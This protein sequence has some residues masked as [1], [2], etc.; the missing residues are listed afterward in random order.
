MGRDS[1]SPTP[2]TSPGRRSFQGFNASSMRCGMSIVFS[3]QPKSRCL[4]G[5][6]QP[7][8]PFSFC[9][10]SYGVRVAFL[11]LLLDASRRASLK[12][13]DSR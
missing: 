10:Q 7:A 11:K 12:E 6:G 9:H 1:N 13:A 2:A 5:V 4:C 8:P 3:Y